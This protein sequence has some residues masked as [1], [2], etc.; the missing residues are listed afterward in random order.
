MSREAWRFLIVVFV[1]AFLL[2]SGTAFSADFNFVFGDQL[3]TLDT[4]KGTLQ[5]NRGGNIGTVTVK[6][7]LTAKEMEQVQKKMDEID[8]WSKEK[9][10]EVFLGISQATL[11]S[12]E[13]HVITFPYYTY[14]FLVARNGQSKELTW[15]DRYVHMT[16]GPAEELRGLTELIWSFVKDKSVYKNLPG[17]GVMRQ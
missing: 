2:F 13:G 3:N 11:D 6:L 16:Y 9:Y 1:F 17:S 7:S 12:D 15:Q 8:F 10:P 14:H 5:S 4:A